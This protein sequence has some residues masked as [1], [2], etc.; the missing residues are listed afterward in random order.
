[1]KMRHLAASLTTAALAVVVAAPTASAHSRQ[2]SGTTELGDR[3][4]AAVL[5]AKGGGTFDRNWYDYDIVTQAVLAVLGAKP[6]S[7]VKALTEGTTALTAFLP[8][9]RAFQ[10]LDRKLNGKAGRTESAVFSSLATKQGIDLIE[11]VLLYHVVPGATIDSKAASK[12]NGVN[13][14]TAMGATFKVRV[15]SPRIPL[16]TLIDQAPGVGNPF[17]NPWALNINKGNKQIAHGITR[18]LLPIAV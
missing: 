15:L 10:I 6:D 4:L 5:T 17:V 2:D 9:D 18:V 7:P 13:L 14:T 3:S 12:A 11:T 8:N 16:I 1:M